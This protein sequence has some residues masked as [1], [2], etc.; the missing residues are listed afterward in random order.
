MDAASPLARTVADL[1]PEWLTKVLVGSGALDGGFV[2]ALDVALLGTGQAGS[3]VRV[4]PH[5][6]GES[7]RAPESVVVKLASLDETARRTGVMMGVYEAEV[8]FYR[9]LAATVDITVP[10][11]HLAEID[12]ENGWFTLVLSD[13][14]AAAV[15]GDMVRG[16]SVDQAATALE[17][18]IKLQTP[19][20]DDPKLASLNWL[21]PQRTK[22][23]FTVFAQS[24]P[25]FLERFG[26]QLD[27]DE[28]E[29][30]ERVAPRAPEWCDIAWSNGP[31]VIQHGDYRL[32]NMLFGTADSAP[33]LTVIDW[34]ASRL[35]PPL[36]DPAFYLGSCLSV[37][38]R[39]DHELELL[40]DYHAGLVAHGVTDYSWNRC[41]D[42][43][44][45][46]CLYGLM[47]WA[48]S[49]THV[50]RTE[51]GDALYLS[52][53]RRHA[54]QALDLDAATLLG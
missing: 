45:L 48:G 22:M 24:V 47:A 21:D 31:F 32:D 8:R 5:Y 16:G 52:G 35:G 28:I 42:D 54:A 20:W 27:H 51:R 29:L 50:E 25:V 46:Q 19:R 13:L 6:R 44:R 39:R 7:A 14:S 2:D 33:A 12:L 1:T 11:C 9:E 10:D 15:V 49:S 3:T 36:L 18:L 38:D 41:W 17:E 4:V 40:R 53:F 23:I 26:S 37:S 43:Y 30:C 34:Q